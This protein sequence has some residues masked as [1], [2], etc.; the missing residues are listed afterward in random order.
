MVD[1]FRYGF[2]GQS[3]VPPVVSLAIVVATLAVVAGVALRMLQTG[4]RIRH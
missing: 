1:G 2:F 3:D 4:W